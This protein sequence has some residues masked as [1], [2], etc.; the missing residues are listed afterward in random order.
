MGD[1]RNETAPCKQ[2]LHQ[3][4]REDDN[5][6]FMNVDANPSAKLSRDAGQSRRVR[7]HS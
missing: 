7:F 2:P 4:S 3:K 6:I 1:C 5:D